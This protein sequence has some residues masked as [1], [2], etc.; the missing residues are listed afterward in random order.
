MGV[1]SRNAVWLSA[2]AWGAKD[3]MAATPRNRLPTVR[4]RGA[5]RPIADSPRTPALPRVR[6]RLIPEFESAWGMR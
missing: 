1:Y 3:R 6:L 5:N 2:C 4:E